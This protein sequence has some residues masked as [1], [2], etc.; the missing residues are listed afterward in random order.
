MV[1]WKRTNGWI[2]IYKTLQ[3]KL[4]IEQHELQYKPVVHTGAHRGCT[5]PAPLVA[6]AVL[7][8]NII[9]NVWDHN[10]VINRSINKFVDSYSWQL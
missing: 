1:K 4:K 6:S 3:M 5:V 2:L 9:L 10:K 7:L 8:S